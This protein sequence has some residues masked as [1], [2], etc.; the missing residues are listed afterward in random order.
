MRKDKAVTAAI[1]GDI[2]PQSHGRG[3]VCNPDIYG[4]DI[5]YVISL[6][7]KRKLAICSW[8]RLNCQDA[9]LLSHRGGCC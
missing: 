5:S 4:S 7:R 6:Q 9:P 1:A 2:Q 3:F 8:I